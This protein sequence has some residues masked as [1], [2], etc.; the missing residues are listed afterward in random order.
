M[1]S[2]V[3]PAAATCGSWASMI[4]AAADEAKVTAGSAR[5]HHLTALCGARKASCS[6]RLPEAAGVTPTSR[7]TH[8]HGGTSTHVCGVAVDFPMEGTEHTHANV[9]S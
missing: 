7:Q 2:N 3:R 6:G 8:T 5:C 9:P 1:R 4:T